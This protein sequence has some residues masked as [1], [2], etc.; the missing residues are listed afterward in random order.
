MFTSFTCDINSFPFLANYSLFHNP[1]SFSLFPANH[2]CLFIC[3]A[4]NDPS[5]S[6]IDHAD[7]F[8]RPQI[9]FYLLS[10]LL[11]VWS[12]IPLFC[13]DYKLTSIAFSYRVT[14]AGAKLLLWFPGF[15]L[16]FFSPDWKSRRSTTLMKAEDPL[17]IYGGFGE[18]T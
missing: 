3:L 13:Y 5:Y 14:A 15:R 9:T 1:N 11:H 4:I 12:F 16:D 17:F 7:A 10:P 6:Y 2:T 8:L 18:K